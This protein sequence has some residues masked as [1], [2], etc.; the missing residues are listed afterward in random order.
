MHRVEQLPASIKRFHE[1][2]GVVEFAVFEDADGDPDT[3][4]NAVSA[5]LQIEDPESLRASSFRRIEDADFYG[6]WYEPESDS[7]LRI[8]FWESAAGELVNPRLRDLP[9]ETLAGGG[10]V[11]EA[12]NG[13]EFAYA[14]SHPPYGLTAS[15]REVQE[16]FDKVRHYIMPPGVAHEISDWTSSNLRNASSYFEAGME[17]WGVFLFAIYLPDYRRLTIAYASTTD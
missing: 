10:P 4:F 3:I 16:L 13:G 1:I 7:L 15:P 5:S 8:G 17:W 11:P 6:K 12:G 2:G 14:F 9:D